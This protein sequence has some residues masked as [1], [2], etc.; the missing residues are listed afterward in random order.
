MR[1]VAAV[2]LAAGNSQRMGRAK[3]LLQIGGRSLIR[4]AAEAAAEA[5]CAPV[6]VVVGARTD[7]VEAELSGSGAEIVRN[8]AWERGI[9]TSIRA[10]VARILALRHQPSAMALMLCDQPLVNAAVLGRLLAG[11]GGS[12]RPV[13]A[14]EFDGTLGPPVIVDASLFPA[15]LAL[16]DDRGAKAL[17]MER[18]EIVQ[19]VACPEAGMDVDTPEDFERLLRECKRLDPGR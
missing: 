2:I 9:G 7:E 16:R 10:G 8:E 3:Q 17:W 14:A 12:G 11:H 18:P 6:V 15:L 1:D 13:T 5:G 19:R 4:R